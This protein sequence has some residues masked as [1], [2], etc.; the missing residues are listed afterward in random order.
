[1]DFVGEYAPMWTVLKAIWQEERPA[2]DEA[3]RML[4][5][6]LEADGMLY[7]FGCG[8][9][10]MIEEELFYVPEA[11]GM[12]PLFESST[13]LHEGAAKSSRIERMSGYAE[14]VIDRMI[15]GRGCFFGG[16][17]QRY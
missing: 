5:C 2:I 15:L 13:M 12:S 17:K 8:H 7:V 6:S 16:V 14:L 4:A 9:S 11:W 1:M 3:G 10:H